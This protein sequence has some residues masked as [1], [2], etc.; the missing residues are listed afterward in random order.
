M[1]IQFSGKSCK[2]CPL[3]DVSILTQGSTLSR[4]RL[5][6]I[7]SNLYNLEYNEKEI[8]EGCPFKTDK[9]IEIVATYIPTELS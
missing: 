3:V 6:R 7:N 1:K 5:S 8:P 4:C 2:E 9:V